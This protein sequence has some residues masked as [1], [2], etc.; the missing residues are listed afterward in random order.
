MSLNQFLKAYQLNLIKKELKL[1]SRTKKY[2]AMTYGYRSIKTMSKAYTE[3]F[4]CEITLANEHP[5]IK[6]LS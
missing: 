6:K 4:N 5:E 3:L 1:G 2:C